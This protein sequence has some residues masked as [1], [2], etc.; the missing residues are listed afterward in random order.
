MDI[1]RSSA[2]DPWRSIEMAIEVDGSKVSITRHY[3]AGSRAVQESMSLDTELP[4]QTVKVEGWW[5]NRHIGA[6]LGNENQEIVSAKWLDES[7]TLQLN[8]ELVLESSQGS[9]KVRILR[10]LKLSKDGNTLREI[11]IRSIRNLPVTRTFTRI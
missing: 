4:S 10:E 5:D 1:S 2:P 11:Q 7:Q 3:S 8:I 9:S 6:Y